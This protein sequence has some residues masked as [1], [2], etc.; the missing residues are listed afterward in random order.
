MARA[1]VLVVGACVAGVTAA[2]E[3]TKRG[4]RVELI[5]RWEPGHP[6]AS[7]TDYN[8]IIHAISGRDEF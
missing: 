8:R 6:R 1:N 5:D 2:F 7:S 3:L 4:K